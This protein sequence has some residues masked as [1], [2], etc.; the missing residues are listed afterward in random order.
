MSDTTTATQGAPQGET[1][2]EPDTKA[3]TT[4]SEATATATDSAEQPNS[5]DTGQ[6]TKPEPWFMRRINQQSAK[7]AALARQNEALQAMMNA[8][9]PTTEGGTGEEAAVHTPPQPNQAEIDRKATEIAN[10]REFQR[11]FDAFDA[12]GRKEFP[13]FREKCNTLASIGASERPD[14]MPIVLDMPEAH[15]IIVQLADNPDEAERILSLPTPRLALELAKLSLA[16][17]KP[18]SS[19]PEPI[20]PLGGSAGKTGDRLAD[21]APVSEWMKAREKQIAERRKQRQR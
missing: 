17:P 13:D 6:K 11:K 15:K 2:A 4:G 8:Q 20:K 21:D 14:F 1:V 7:I 9:R 5:D 19:A 16:K 3:S 18:V 12:L 10:Q